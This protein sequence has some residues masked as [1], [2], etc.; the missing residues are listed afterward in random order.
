MIVDSNIKDN[1]KTELPFQSDEY[2]AI[3][4]Q[5]LSIQIPKTKV[6]IRKRPLNK[7][8]I[9]LKEI[10]NISII[11]ENK[12]VVS[13]LKKNLDLSQH[14]DKKDFFLIKYLMINLQM[15]KFM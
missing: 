1:S 12:V 13:E 6:I 5:R 15:T 10:D 9:S 11:D 2:R 4:N 8:E 14:I 7:K 3:L